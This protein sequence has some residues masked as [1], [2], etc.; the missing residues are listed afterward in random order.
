MLLFNG[1]YGLTEEEFV[2][3]KVECIQCK[4]QKR[5]R[6]KKKN[7]QNLTENGEPLSTQTHVIRVLEK[8]R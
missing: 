3:L 6:K 5:K 7:Q 8:E 1:R 4:K 2:N